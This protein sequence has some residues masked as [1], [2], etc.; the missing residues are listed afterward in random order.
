MAKYWIPFS[1]GRQIRADR[2]DAFENNDAGARV[3]VHGAEMQVPDKLAARDDGQV[4]RDDELN[5]TRPVRRA[6]QQ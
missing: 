5:P 1:N 2:I 4:M 6:R 3:W